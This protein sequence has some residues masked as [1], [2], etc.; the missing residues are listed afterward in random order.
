MSESPIDTLIA[1]VQVWDTEGRSSEAS[2][3]ERDSILRATCEQVLADL[4]P[5][6]GMAQPD[7]MTDD[8][9]IRE[10]RKIIKEKTSQLRKAEAVSA[11][12]RELARTRAQEN[13]EH[14][15]SL[16][17][18]SFRSAT[19]HHGDFESICTHVNCVLVR[20]PHGEQP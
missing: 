17:P 12:L 16:K 19:G 4:I 2:P 13:H 9:V 7:Y 10:L 1:A 20:A 8:V 14:A 6:R 3:F 5:T 18:E 11:R 15:L